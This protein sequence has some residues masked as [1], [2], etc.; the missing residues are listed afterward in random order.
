MI[1]H[2]GLSRPIGA[3]E[4]SVNLSIN[5]VVLDLS[6]DQ[7]SPT[8]NSST[9][10]SGSWLLPV[11]HRE[12]GGGVF[13]L[14]PRRFI[15]NEVNRLPWQQLLSYLREPAPSS[16]LTDQT[17]WPGTPTTADGGGCAPSRTWR[18]FHVWA[19]GGF[20]NERAEEQN[21]VEG[22]LV[23]HVTFFF[24]VMC[25]LVDLSCHAFVSDKTER[26]TEKNKWSSAVPIETAETHWT[27]STLWYRCRPFI[28]RQL[29][30]KWAKIRKT[31]CNYPHEGFYW[32][33]TRSGSH[34]SLQ[35]TWSNE[36]LI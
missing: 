26:K 9:G 20:W 32:L 14:R 12:R 19:E 23:C 10:S 17:C 29:G 7:N 15:V 27:C 1:N 30:H 22:K 28:K 24:W 5:C 4:I 35:Y 6:V 11:K 21:D 16:Q 2:L 36:K 3:H 34:H 8:L 13:F 18:R 33:H 31:A 25:A